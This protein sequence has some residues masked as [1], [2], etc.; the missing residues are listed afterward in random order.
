MSHHTVRSA[1]LPLLSVLNWIYFVSILCAHVCLAH[2]DA[3]W[4]SSLDAVRDH[5]WRGAGCVFFVRPA[6]HLPLLIPCRSAVNESDQ[7]RVS[8]IVG[9][10]LGQIATVEPVTERSQH[11]QE[12]KNPRRH[13]FLCLVTFIVDLW[14]PKQM[15]FR[16]SW[17]NISVSSLVA[18]ISTARCCVCVVYAVTVCLSVRP[19]VTRRY[20]IKTAK[21]GITQTA[22]YESPGILVFWHQRFR[23]NSF[24]VTPNGGAK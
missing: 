14:T 22:L 18:A 3:C 5:S 15:D 9:A 19:S 11:S 6:A 8:D 21:P 24:E 7:L 13:R 20:C 12:C 1:Q 2:F 16:D 23:R 10:C 17:W 4:Y